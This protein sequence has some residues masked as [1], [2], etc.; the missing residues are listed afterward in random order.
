MEL[1][2]TFDDDGNLLGL[3]PRN[4]VHRLGLWH[5]AAH[6]LVFR[7]SGALLV[8]Q[9]AADKDL[10]AN[11]LDFSV[12]EH[13]QPGETYEQGAV[14]GMREEL[15]IVDNPVESLGHRP[16]LRFVDEQLGVRD[17]EILEVFKSVFDGAIRP[18]P[19]EVAQV[20]EMDPVTL[21]RETA[22]NPERFTPWFLDDLRRQGLI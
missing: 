16:R 14:R 8:Q 9:R 5:R 11:M 15:G 1:F 12:G 4:E 22:A 18:D 13:L 19:V 2:E 6:V 3:V 17:F 7:S 10:Y 20:L 21:R